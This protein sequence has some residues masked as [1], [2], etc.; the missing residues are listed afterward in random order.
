MDRQSQSRRYKTF[1]ASRVSEIHQKSSPR[2]WRHVPT[3]L[4]CAYDATRGL[5]AMVLT[6]DHRWF[7]GPRFLYEHEDD[8]P[9][10]TCVVHEERSHECLTE[11]VK[12]KMTFALEVSQPLMNPL[13]FTSWN[14]L[15]RHSVGETIRRYII[16]Q[17]KE[18]RVNRVNKQ[19]CCHQEP[20][21]ID[22]RRNRQSWKTG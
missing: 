18:T 20:A 15:R 21:Y 7:S 8:W 1:V 14:R 16:G 3:D 13:K 10:G 19:R 12:P 22:P 6:S 5:H 9:Q 11:I 17:G 2:Q 4:N